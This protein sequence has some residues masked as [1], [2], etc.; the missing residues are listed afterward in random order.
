[1]ADQ[2]QGERVDERGREHEVAG[3]AV[4]DL[5]ALVRD[6]R[7]RRDEVGPAVSAPVEAAISH[8]LPNTRMN[9]TAASDM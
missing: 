8:L 7:D 1:M 9:G 4:D 2:R 3:V 6:A 5:Q